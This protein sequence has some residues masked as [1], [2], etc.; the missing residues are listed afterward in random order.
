MIGSLVVG[1]SS[2]N[3]LAKGFDSL[4]LSDDVIRVHFE[5]TTSTANYASN[6]WRIVINDEAIDG[7]S[8]FSIVDAET[9]ETRFR[10]DANAPEN[11][12]LVDALGRLGLGTNTPQQDVHIQGGDTPTVRLEQTGTDE[13]TA[14]IWDVAGNEVNFFVQNST[15]GELVPF[16]IHATAT[17]NSLYITEDGNI[18]IGTDAANRS[19][20]V[21]RDDGTAQV[22]ITERSETTAERE[23]L[24]LSNHGGSTI[25]ITD[26]SGVDDVTW[27]TGVT[28]TDDFVVDLSSTTDSE[29][30]IGSNGQLV[31]GPDGAENFLLDTN[32]NLTIAG[33]LSQG[34]SYTLKENFARLNH[35]TVLQRLNALPIY[36]WNYIDDGSGVQHL[37][38]TAEDFFDMFGLGAD[39]QHIAASDMITVA[40]SGLQGL[41]ESV[42]HQ[43]QQLELISNSNDLTWT[44]AATWDPTVTAIPD[45]ID[46][47]AILQEATPSSSAIDQLETITTAGHLFSLPTADANSNSA[48]VLHSL[49]DGQRHEDESESLFLA[50]TGTDDFFVWQD[51]DLSTP[52]VTD[53]YYDFRNEGVFENQITPMQQTIAE[54]MLAA[55]ETASDGSIQFSRNTTV[56]RTEII[57]LGVGALE[58]FGFSSQAGGTL[59][60]GGGVVT[61][62]ISDSITNGVV[63]LDIAENWDLVTG[64]VEPDGTYDMATVFLHEIGHSLGLGHTDHVAGVDVMDGFYQGEALTFSAVD[65]GLIQTLYADASFQPIVGDGTLVLL[66]DRVNFGDQFFA[67]NVAVGDDAT[68]GVYFG[69]DTLRLAENNLRIGFNDT[70]TD[71]SPSVG[72]QITANDSINGGL[73]YFSFDQQST[74][75]TSNG[76]PK[77]RVLAGAPQ[78]SL[79]IDSSNRIGL[80]TQSPQED[81]HLV[82]GT[83]PTIRLEQ[84]T[85]SGFTGSQW[86]FGGDD[87][88]FFVQNAITSESVFQIE[89]GAADNSLLVGQQGFVGVG[90]DGPDARFHILRD[91]GSAQLRIEETSSVIET[92]NLAVLHNNG[93]ALIRFSNLVLDSSTESTADNPQLGVAKAASVE[94]ELVTFDYTIENL[95]DEEL[96]NLALT[97]DLD[98]LFG[99]YNYS[100]SSPPTLIDGPETIVFNSE[101]DG[102]D[103]TNLLNSG[104]IEGT[105][106]RTGNGTVGSTLA[107]GET[108]QIRVV[109]QLDHLDDQGSGIGNYSTQVSVA[110]RDS[111]GG[112]VTD[113]SDN[114][115]DPD[116]DGNGVPTDAGE[117]DPTAFTV[118]ENPVIGVAADVFIADIETLTID[119]G[120]SITADTGNRVVFTWNVENLGNVDLSDIQLSVDLDSVF[121]AGNYGTVFSGTLPEVTVIGEG[122]LSQNLNFNGSTQQFVISSG[123]LAP[124]SSAIIS[125]EVLVTDI[126]DVGNGL[127]VYSHQASISAKGP[128]LTVTT[129][130]SNAGPKSDPNGNGIANEDGENDPT[131]FA[132]GA[133]IGVALD[134]SVAG[135]DVTFDIYLEAFGSDDLSDVSLVDD[136]DVMFGKD[137]YTISVSPTFV[138]DPGTIS[139]NPDY[140]GSDDQQLLLPGGTLT[141]TDTA[142]ISFTVTVNTLQNNDSGLGVYEQQ[143]TATAKDPFGLSVS[144]LSDLGTDPDPNGDENPETAGEE[145][146]SI[147]V[148]S[149]DAVVG[150]A[151]QVTVDEN[152]VT[153]DLFLENFGTETTEQLSL[154]DNLDDVFGVG[155]YT[156]TVDP[157]LIVDPG[158]LALNAGFDGHSDTNLLDATSTLASGATAQIQFAVEVLQLDDPIGLGVGVY[159]HQAIVSATDSK[160]LQVIDR[161]DDQTDPDSRDSNGDPTNPGLQDPPVDGEDDANFFLIGEASIGA[162]L[163]A[164]V[165]GTEVTLDYTIENLGDHTITD[166]AATQS[167]F[168]VF[169]FGNFSTVT[170]A[171]LIDGPDSIV[172]NSNFDGTFSTTLASNSSLAAGESARIRYVLDVST[173]TNNQGNGFGVYETSWNVVGLD[174]IGGV[175]TDTSTNGILTDP[176]GDGDATESDENAATF[177][178][179]GQEPSIGISTDVSVNESQVTIDYYGENLGNVELTS[180]SLTQDL[181]EIFGESNYS[182]SGQPSLIDDPGTLNPNLLFDGTT[183][184]DLLASGSTLAAGDTFQLRLIVD[185]VD[186]V[187]L[188]FGI[189]KYRQQTRITGRSSSGNLVGDFSIEG[190]DP[191]PNGNGIPSDDG[192]NGFTPFTIATSQIGTALNAAIDG[193]LVTLTYQIENLGNTVLD[194]F[195][196]LVD[197]DSVFGADNYVV[198]S[199]PS[200]A[201][202]RPSL[203]LDP[204]FDGRT[205]QELI[206]SGQLSGGLVDV[207]ELVVRVDSI[208]DQGSGVGV[209]SH[210]V[211]VSADSPDDTLVT[212]LSNA[213]LVA[214]SNGNANGSDA[215][216][217]DPT[218]IE[219]DLVESFVVTTVVDEDNGTSDAAFGTGTS[220]REAILL[221]N[222]TPGANTITF[223]P[224]LAGQT[225]TLDSG[226]ANAGDTSALLVDDDLIIEGLTSGEGVILAIDPLA[227]RRHFDV[228]SMTSLTLSDLTLTGG[229][230]SGGGGALRNQGSLTL[231]RSTFTGNVAA[232]GGA[233]LSSS[234]SSLLSITNVTFAGNT[235]S[236]DGGAI[237]SGAANNSLQNV[238]IVDNTSG[239]DGG[240]L[241][242]SQQSVTLTNVILSRN[243]DGIDSNANFNAI[244]GGSIHAASRNNLID[245][246]AESL[247][248]GTL[249][250][251]GGPTQTVAI[252]A[253]SPARNA[254]VSVS[255]IDSDQRG[256]PRL[257]EDAVDIGAVEFIPSSLVVTVLD[258]DSN[259][260]SSPGDLSFYEAV[261]LADFE[262]DASTIT[263]DPLLFEDGSQVVTLTDS[264]I[265]SNEFGRSAF[266]IST[267]VSIVGPSG[268]HGLTIQSD[269]GSGASDEETFRAFQVEAAGRLS[270]TNVTLTGFESRGADGVSGDDASAGVGGAIYVSGGEL[271]LSAVLL[272]NNLASGG[273]SSGNAGDGFGGGVYVDGGTLSAVNTTISGNSAIGGTGVINGKGVGGGLAVRNG[274]IELLNTTIANNNASEG[275]SLYVVGD[276]GVVLVDL[277]NSILADSVA[278][279][280]YFEAT[281][282]SGT[283]TDT[284][285]HNLIEA[286]ASAF[287]GTNTLSV[288]P[289]LNLLAD[290]GGPTRTHAPLPAS[291]I[292]DAGNDASIG[293]ISVDQRGEARIIRDSIDLGAVEVQPTV[294][295]AADALSRDEQDSNATNFTF[296]VTRFNSVIGSAT[297]DYEV[298]GMTVST[299]DF[300]GESLPSGTVA[301]A[302]GETTR[303]IT[304]AVL[305]DLIVEQDEA[306]TVTLK[307]PSSG[308]VIETNAASS[309]IANDDVA[310][311]SIDDVT[312]S[313]ADG[314]FTFT[315][316]LSQ[317]VDVDVTIDYSTTADS[318]SDDDFTTTSG[319]A[320]ISAG[321][322]S[323][324]VSVMV[325]SDDIVERDEQFFFNLSNVQAGGR[326]VTIADTQSVATITNDDNA[327]VQIDDVTQDEE[328][329]VMTF[330]IS[331]DEIVDTDVSVDFGTTTDSANDAD[332][333]ETSGTA[334]ISAGTTSTTVTVSITAD[335]TVEL[336]EQFYV[337]LT[338]LMAAGRDVA[339]ADA[340]GTGTLTNDD[341]TGLRID[342]VTQDENSGMMTF[343]LTLDEAVDADV[344]VEYETM[345]DSATGLDFTA[346]SGTATIAAGSRTT[347][348]LVPISAD[349]VV[350]LDERF[351]VKLSNVQASGRDVT[352]L[353]STGTGTIVNADVAKIRIADA[354]QDE[355]AGVISFTVT[356]DEAVDTDV[357]IDFSTANQSATDS[358]FT[359][360]SGTATIAAG[361][362]STTISI[363]IMADDVV[364]LDEQFFVHLA[365]VQAAQRDVTILDSTGIGHIVNDDAARI[366]IDDV[367][368]AEHAGVMTF[369]ISLD[370]TTD[371][372]VSVKFATQPDTAFSNDF[373]ATSGMATI[374]AGSSSTMISVAVNADQRVE[375][376]ERLLVDLSNV[377]AAGRAVTISDSRGVGNI[378]NDDATELTINDVVRDERS[379][380][381]TF[382]IALD[383]VVDADVMV[384]YST[385]TGTADSSDFTMKSGTA[386]IAAGTT[387]AEIEVVIQDDEIVE[388]NEQFRMNLANLR[389]NGRNV[390][391]VDSQGIGTI[392][393]DE[394]ASIR[395]DHFTQNEDAGVMTFTLTTDHLLDSDV[396]I[397][398]ST[399]A[400]GANLSDLTPTSGTVTI[401]AGSSSANISVPIT[402]DNQVELDERFFVDLANAQADGRDVTI[403]ESQGVGTISNDDAATISIDDIVQDEDAGTMTFTITLDRIVDADVSIDFSTTADEVNS[404][405]FT[406]V[407][408]TATIAAGSTS[409]T[410]TVAITPDETV[411]LDERVFVTLENVQSSNRDVTITDSQGIGTIRN[412][413]AANVRIGDV[414]Q[415]EDSGAM[416]FVVTIDRRVDAE[417]ILAYE[418]VAGT[419]DNDD[420]R[421]QTGQLVIPAH[422]TSG[423]ITIDVLADAVVELDE[424]F[425]VRLTQLNAGGRNVQ[426]ADSH[427]LGE[428]ENDDSARLFIDNVSI[429]EG[430]RGERDLTF[431]VTL[432]AAVDRG[433]SVNV[434]TTDGTAT[435]AD[436]DYIG[437][438]NQSLNFAGLV[439]ETQRFSV[440]IVGD[441]EIELDETIV[442]RLSNLQANERD[443][444]ISMAEAEGFIV[445]DDLGTNSGQVIDRTIAETAVNITY[446]EAVSGNFDAS[447]SSVDADDLF[448][449]DPS[450]GSNR[451][452]FG[453]GTIQNNPVAVELLN[454]RSFVQILAGNFDDGFGTDLF[455]WNPVDGQNRLIHFSGSTGGVIGNSEEN[456]L[457]TTQINGQEF[458][459]VVAG[460]FDGGGPDDLFFWDPLTGRNRLAHVES[461]TN[462]SQ[463]AVNIVQDETISRTVING[464][465]TSLRVGQFAEGGLDELYFVNLSTG[466]NRLVSLALETPGETTEFA[467]FETNL[468]SPDLFNNQDFNQLEVADLNGDGLSD[469]F[470]WNTLTGAN[471]AAVTDP[472]QGESPEIV[473]DLFGPQGI[474]GDYSR[475]VRL[476]D[477]VFSSS[478]IDQL[479]FWNPETGQNRLANTTR[480]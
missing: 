269:F 441:E 380:M 289:Q 471:R 160:G 31:I 246:S 17:A 366:Q 93:G 78:D 4:R 397:D 291:P 334:T 97:D 404:E 99:A 38:P 158:T 48:L 145:T 9:G 106:G 169:G 65:R 396:S 147:F 233:I 302:D 188:G 342:D 37:G 36:Q 440:Q 326:D 170:Q 218:S 226:W 75:G 225:I 270:L 203:V 103:E 336:D 114:G 439:N 216:E 327:S 198:V 13:Y 340:S 133:N 354:T 161:S 339:I 412:D 383:R 472:D 381:L 451:I 321:S 423:I 139:L 109:I 392:R 332:F 450:T 478:A 248:I 1:N 87:H 377:Q 299:D 448:F 401:L 259:G 433:V 244:N 18:G 384:D 86:D 187:D 368:Q 130:V 258:S 351:F 387:T 82:R 429:V 416:N 232:E 257:I 438:I 90:H 224:E 458:T 475:V 274:Q 358:D 357:S 298:S 229:N 341:A 271:E 149:S 167:L 228:S 213:G 323:T 452:V 138:D 141:A 330:T 284:G 474:N 413:D 76:S 214:D 192:E 56:D 394:S 122:T 370:Q 80:G 107:V 297:V 303:T 320:T 431:T 371:V 236:S 182:I 273:D 92:R 459:T 286:G 108:A 126:V 304:I 101:F 463:S 374:L 118:A 58:T 447:P 42:A 184:P 135:A 281:F 151:S 27:Q 105:D 53:I 234:D 132:L 369:T 70:S 175:Y 253:D 102:S 215:A 415:T 419:T 110:G 81:L 410:V 288:D 179:I 399:S 453:D 247:G 239:V 50:E 51:Q 379:G 307:D 49:Q 405:D 285:T 28:S 470:A 199:P 255:G 444:S 39:A 422:T 129:D 267:D 254:G 2:E 120:G 311:V 191:D 456:V 338:N 6:D 333:T 61:S 473:E 155:N 331:I 43:G 325:S 83:S 310:T 434:S 375:L 359:G 290:N 306:F 407:S 348:V 230:V 421:P 468:I 426:I 312:Q 251:N 168:P 162:S 361:T 398:F 186:L 372:D 34:S 349:G 33:T 395:I 222:S 119:V 15:N 123:T 293:S 457:P 279:N 72:W 125:T 173:V 403:S 35:S 164:F 185:V 449:W 156:I 146:A 430:D 402:A 180:L 66:E 356:L 264:N 124:G 19:V 208:T 205:N 328:A 46:V 79:V 432:D 201:S 445:N 142:Q 121:G 400:D 294:S 74:P 134:T 143:L 41:M 237:W 55:W 376:D 242:V 183:E 45:V 67:N 231:H 7:E 386:T 211:S 44:S 408:G 68:N 148:V 3:G 241:A 435:V 344:T 345:T 174:P 389:T 221:A 443:V 467:A 378:L 100:I 217:D 318:A 464:D 465:Y 390:S 424:Q 116:P 319:S 353:D 96:T 352:I 60:V 406:E 112:L 172:V 153:F 89:T 479:F 275:G 347:T 362:T 20:H 64:N 442:A 210:Q 25:A 14:S 176:D 131:P 322:T 309:S 329:G 300:V 280:D 476:T 462:G 69:T 460:N 177:I 11:A 268:M 85:S 256:I 420:L 16:K 355:D 240:A 388:L 437:S 115:T 428:I 276:G 204:D 193:S 315:I 305:G 54:S 385:M 292:I 316:A 296:T 367:T 324:T 5:D 63:W 94:G 360:L 171:T 23:L 29:F 343:T 140:D 62:G 117:N 243:T 283:V 212:D 469:L 262:P 71:G 308:I 32:G 154:N 314:E 409:T 30:A 57:N 127:G 159:R 335:D 220:L 350:E 166:I 373:S 181:D 427:G 446:S 414:R 455:F 238:T 150:V 317:P 337:E 194:D 77:F 417:L 200:L 235:A 189:G 454:G 88:S 436:G 364:E 128:D 346:T 196:L 144:D 263:F 21:V 206:R 165:N 12:L 363:A 418:T 10:I 24:H 277:N 136:L 209:Y 26:A 391:L 111:I 195:S 272:T 178:I 227:E 249:A 260:N 52:D 261:R 22:M 480:R 137:N 207:I 301:F 466:Q 202:S 313:E 91:D 157:V 365:N 113:L 245:I 425:Q 40:L 47:E 98:E 73:S 104:V 252:L 250:D 190:T 461:V 287:S 95:G 265:T 411:E 59:A 219:F 282:N 393:N 382:Q 152:T 8:H 295:I 266:I 197:L 223:A 278:N 477:E 84:D 163:I